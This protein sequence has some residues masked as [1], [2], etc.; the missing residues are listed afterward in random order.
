MDGE[1]TDGAAATV[2]VCVTCRGADPDARPGRT[3]FETVSAR[4]RETAEGGITVVPVE[5][6]AVCKRPCT[7]ALAAAGKWTSVVGDLD[8]S[9]HADD[10]VTAALAYGASE[11]GIIPWRQRP[12]SFRKGVVSRTPPAGFRPPPRDPDSMA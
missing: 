9:L 8:P 5:C 2:F 11:N 10:V 6:L 12:A 4:M 1:E 3:L 7:V